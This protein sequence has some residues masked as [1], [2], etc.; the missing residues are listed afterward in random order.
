MQ[1]HPESF[2]CGANAIRRDQLCL[3]PHWDVQVELNSHGAPTWVEIRAI[4][5]RHYFTR[6]YLFFCA[7]LSFVCDAKL[8]DA[9]YAAEGCLQGR[10]VFRGAHGGNDPVKMLP[11]KPPRR[12]AKNN[13]GDSPAGKVLLVTHVL[14][15]RQQQIEAGAIGQLKQF[16]V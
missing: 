12:V 6:H 7:E 16:S 9:G 11:D 10:D 13:D 15:G 2:C 4:A 8:L 1:M 14:V 5:E 3:N